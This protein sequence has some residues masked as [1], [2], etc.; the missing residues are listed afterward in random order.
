LLNGMRPPVP[1]AT[2]EVTKVV[3]SCKSG[4]IE[5]H[6]KEVLEVKQRDRKTRTPTA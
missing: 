5:L 6:L 4:Q 2:I 3:T 1:E